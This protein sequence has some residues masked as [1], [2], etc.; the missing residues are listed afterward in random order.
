MCVH[1]I[2]GTQKTN[3]NCRDHTRFDTHEIEPQGTEL[4]EH[5]HTL[6]TSGRC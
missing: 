5:T 1:A 2:F 6:R 4:T 3:R